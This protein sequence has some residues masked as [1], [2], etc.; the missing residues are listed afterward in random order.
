MFPFV[1]QMDIN[2]F[3]HSVVF[4]ITLILGLICLVLFVFL[5]FYICDFLN[6][7][8]VGIENLTTITVIADDCLMLNNIPQQKGFKTAKIWTKL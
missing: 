6:R 8:T 7:E 2:S 5:I 3:G 4:S 1:N